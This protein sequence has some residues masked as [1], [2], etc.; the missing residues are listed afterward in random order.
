[1][2]YNDLSKQD[3]RFLQ[4]FS[5]EDDNKIWW[6][7]WHDVMKEC[8]DEYA[9]QAVLMRPA[10]NIVDLRCYGNV[11]Y[12]TKENQLFLVYNRQQVGRPYELPKTN[13]SARTRDEIIV[14]MAVQHAQDMDLI[15]GFEYI[16]KTLSEAG[17]QQVELTVL[18]QI[19]CSIAGINTYEEFA[20]AMY[21]ALKYGAGYYMMVADA[22]SWRP[23]QEY[24]ED[25]K[26][27]KGP[28]IEDWEFSNLPAAENG[29][30]VFTKPSEFEA[31]VKQHITGDDPIK[32]GM[33]AHR[34]IAPQLPILPL[35]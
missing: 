29:E 7:F 1:M 35:E 19:F 20:A 22:I 3:K 16:P 25:L 26:K 30:Y 4:A 5:R 31:L 9:L 21:P 28:Q 10:F 8:E 32:A 11:Q 6:R 17:R 27:I 14:P 23:K 13:L 2:G 34:E 15:V 18:T 24:A 12:I 33:E